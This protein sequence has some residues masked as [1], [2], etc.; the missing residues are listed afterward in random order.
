MPVPPV[1]LRFL[2]L[3][4]GTRRPQKKIRFPYLSPLKKQKQQSIMSTSLG[5]VNENGPV[6]KAA[7]QLITAYSSPESRV[8]LFMQN[9]SIDHHRRHPIYF[10]ISTRKKPLP[11]P[12]D[13]PRFQPED[14]APLPCG[15]SKNIF[16][17]VF[18]VEFRV[19]T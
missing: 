8:S 6:L 15:G 16:I 4:N 7:R 10:H 9:K 12:N 1:L 19:P 17:N 5:I 11:I 14:I 3:F 13:C 2:L 18:P